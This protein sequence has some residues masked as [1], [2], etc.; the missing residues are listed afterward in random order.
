MKRE[1][2]G[3][4]AGTNQTQNT[5]LAQ[6]LA[7]T[8]TALDL[9]MSFLL[10]RWSGGTLA[11]EQGRSLAIKKLTKRYWLKHGRNADDLP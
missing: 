10:L 1:I 6:G 3:T 9:L 7:I 8:L 5:L 2:D 11:T 4:I